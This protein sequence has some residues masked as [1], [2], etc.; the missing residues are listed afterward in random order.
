VRDAKLAVGMYDSMI[1]DT[2]V[3]GGERLRSVVA[4]DINSR[5]LLLGGPSRAGAG[6]LMA[7]DAAVAAGSLQCSI[8]KH[9]VRMVPEINSS[10]L[11]RSFSYIPGGEAYELPSQQTAHP[12]GSDASSGM[13]GSAAGSI[14]SMGAA[15]GGRTHLPPTAPRIQMSLS[16]AGVAAG[17]NSMS[18]TAAKRWRALLFC[19]LVR[20]LLLVSTNGIK[21]IC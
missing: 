21:L 9:A 1:T 2:A 5:P 7:A 4:R 10:L 17:S 20:C 11:K 8:P 14:G 3:L 12:G 16:G 6:G 19:V 15:V 13:P 18:M